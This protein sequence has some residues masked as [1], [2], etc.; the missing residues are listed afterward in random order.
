[1]TYADIPSMSRM[2]DTMKPE[3]LDTQGCVALAET[4]LS[5]ASRELFDATREYVLKP[6]VVS[7]ERLKSAQRFFK[8]DWFG[9]LSCGVANGEEAMNAIMEKA[10]RIFEPKAR[11]RYR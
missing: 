2:K 5:E 3:D 10:R 1:M 4:I 7:L 6:S 8:S 9:V 11:S